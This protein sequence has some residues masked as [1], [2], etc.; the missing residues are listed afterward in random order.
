ML[1]ETFR[2]R[3]FRCLTAVDLEPDRKYNLI[4]GPNGSGK[5]SLLEAIFCLSR[6]RSFRGTRTEG[7]VR[8][9]ES[10]FTLFGRVSDGSRVASVGVRMGR[11]LS[12]FRVDGRS[13]VTTASLAEALRV[14]VIDPEVHRLVAGGPEGRRRFLDYGVF[15]VEPRFLDQW[16]RYRKALRHRNALLRDGASDDALAPWDAQFVEYG[17]TLDELRAAHAEALNARFAEIGARLLDAEVGCEYRTG[18]RENESLAAALERSRVQDRDHGSTHVGPHRA[19][20]RLR[21]RRRAARQQV[22]RGQEKLF[23]CA[24]ILAQIGLIKE[25]SRSAPVLLL[26]DPAAELDAEALPR[27]MTAVF[28]TCGQLVVTA[29]DAGDVDFP[30]APAV[31]HVERG[32]V[33]R[34]TV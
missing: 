7:L 8:H 28:E 16:R 22:S 32:T 11:G 30:V 33:E 2:A 9:G 1:L 20:L 3:D 15:H 34:R 6:G 29:L 31:F 23:A 10:A 25:N 13:D 14:Q 21:F 17:A 24:L 27:F 5:T 4:V 19:E 18:Q 12:E 26:D